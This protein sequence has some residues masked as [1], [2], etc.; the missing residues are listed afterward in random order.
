VEKV[1]DVMSVTVNQLLEHLHHVRKHLDFWQG[2]SEVMFLIS[3]SV[4][5]L[6]FLLQQVVERACRAV[7]SLHI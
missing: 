4:V 5:I 6:D 2:L 3:D 7:K 1:V